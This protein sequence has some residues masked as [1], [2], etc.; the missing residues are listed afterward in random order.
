MAVRAAETI[1]D[2]GGV[3]TGHPLVR[4]GR[5]AT[6][7]RDRRPIGDRDLSRPAG[8]VARSGRL[9]GPEAVGAVDRTVHA[10]LERDLGLVAA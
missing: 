5:P 3:P 2:G 8:V 6:G 1:V 10:R 4:E 9:D 7:D